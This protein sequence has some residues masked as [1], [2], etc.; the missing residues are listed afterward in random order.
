MK[1]LNEV[2]ITSV[3]AG[4]STAGGAALAGLNGFGA[5]FA[6]GAGAGAIAGGPAAPIT[7]LVGGMIGGMLGTVGGVYTYFALK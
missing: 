2:E 7:G 5:G 3:S 6:L 1:E 4:N